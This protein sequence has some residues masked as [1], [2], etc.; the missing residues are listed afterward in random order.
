LSVSLRGRSVACLFLIS[1]VFAA[2]LFGVGGCSARQENLLEEDTVPGVAVFRMVDEKDGWALKGSA[3]LRTT[4]GGRTWKT[5][6]PAGTFPEGAGAAFVGAQHARLGVT[7]PRPEAP[8][9]TY[10]RIIRVFRTSDVGA[11]WDSVDVPV[12][13]MGARL[14][15]LDE[16][17]GWIVV[18]Q[19]VA[20]MHEQVA[21]LGTTDGGKTWAQLSSTSMENELGRLPFAGSKNGLSFVTKDRGYVTGYW[22][23]PGSPFFYETLDGGRTWSPVDLPVPAAYASDDVWI[24]PPA[25]WSDRE[26]ALPL[27]FN[28][29]KGRVL[30]F[31][32][33]KDAGETWQPGAQVPLTGDISLRWTSGAAGHII[34][35]TGKDFQ[36]TADAGKTWTRV[37]PSMPGADPENLKLMSFASRKSGWAIVGGLLFRTTDGG[38]AW[39]RT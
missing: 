39:R 26:G 19:G 11:T 13:A 33:T 7:V 35:L 24:E 8:A 32:S 38:K 15:F 25:F 34:V 3:V 21:I 28:G 22:P 31:Y 5:V 4:D 14:V 20:M 36:V 17:T 9:G 10:D 23:V 30:V 37:T 18:P 27:A 1:P 12:T 2:S 16:K 29:E 6:S